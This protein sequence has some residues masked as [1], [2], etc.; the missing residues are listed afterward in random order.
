LAS[1]SSAAIVTGDTNSWWLQD[2][3][4][5]LAATTIAAFRSK[6]SSYLNPLN[7]YAL[8]AILVQPLWFD[9]MMDGNINPP[10]ARPFVANAYTRFK[11]N[12]FVAKP[13]TSVAMAQASPYFLGGCSQFIVEFAGDFLTQDNNPSSATYGQ[14]IQPTGSSLTD[15]QIDYTLVN[16]SKQIKW[17]GL[18]R[19]T[20]GLSGVK[21]LNGDVAPLNAWIVAYG[22]TSYY[23]YT[24]EKIYPAVKA[25]YSGAG[26]MSLSD[27][28]KRLH[29]RLR[30]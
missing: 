29:L 24:F 10:S 17:Y 20:S 18:P 1:N 15:G 3:R 8:S 27:A 22:L 12:P 2:G 21:P 5:D 7:S 19:N 11:C 4:F 25:D 6:L 16:G 13:M 30:P 9:W 23:N 28:T 26:G 14:P